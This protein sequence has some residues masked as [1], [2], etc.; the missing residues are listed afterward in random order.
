MNEW[1]V[2]KKPF[3]LFISINI[4]YTIMLF[5]YWHTTMQPYFDNF[6]GIVYFK[7]TGTPFIYMPLLM[8]LQIIMNT[9]FLSYSIWRMIRK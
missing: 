9:G 6:T 5:L 8:F 1:K 7:V 4:I 3:T 2:L